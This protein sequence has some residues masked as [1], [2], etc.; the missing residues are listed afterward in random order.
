LAAFVGAK[1]DDLVFVPDATFGVNTVLRALRFKP[2]DELLV[3][4]H[5]YNAC[6]NALNCVARDSGARVVVMPIPFPLSSSDEVVEAVLRGVTR[7]TR[8]ALLDHA[9]SSTGLVLPMR[10]LVRELA[11]LGV[12]TLVDGAHG[13]GMLPL[14]LRKLGAAFYT[15]NCHKWLCAPKGAAFLHVRSDLQPH[16]RPLV[17][18]HGANSPRTDRSRFL[19]EF[20]W[21]GTD[22]FSAWLCVPE[23]L[24]CIGGLLPGAWP[25]VMQRNRELALAARRHLCNALDIAP[26]A[27]EDMIG[28]MASIPLPDGKGSGRYAILHGLDELREQ[29]RDEFQIEV[30]VFPWPAPP[31]RLLRVSAQLYNALPDYV[32]LAEAVKRLFQKPTLRA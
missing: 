28:A 17:I 7:R 1:A 10:K 16:I 23:A 21:M 6:R 13:P 32:K 3:T 27:P 20:G 12:E 22:D 2:G 30:P 4:D 14:N 15:G 24:R 26:P 19:I 29:L 8:L 11:A 18:S 25:D 9:T 5:E 31:K